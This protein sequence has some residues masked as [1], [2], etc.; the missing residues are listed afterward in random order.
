MPVAVAVA[1]PAVPD[2]VLL[3]PERRV[4]RGL[5]LKKLPENIALRTVG[6]GFA[7]D[8]GRDAQSPFE[9]LNPSR[10]NPIQDAGTLALE[11]LFNVRDSVIVS[12]LMA[13]WD[14][15]DPSPGSV[16][17]IPDDGAMVCPKPG[18]GRWNEGEV[19]L[20]KETGGNR[21]AAGQ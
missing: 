7:A 10:N 12:E 17:V 16:G 2:I 15:D 21:F 14:G 8:T 13:K 11:L 5:L 1:P 4:R 6:L 18:R 20:V 9:V 3:D 19:F